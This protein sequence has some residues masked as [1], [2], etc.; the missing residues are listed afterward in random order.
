MHAYLISQ[1]GGSGSSSK[2]DTEVAAVA[3]FAPA[4]A[5]DPATGADV[6][7]D[8]PILGGNIGLGGAG[9]RDLDES[10]TV[11]DVAEAEEAVEVTTEACACDEGERGEGDAVVEAGAMTAPFETVTVPAAAEKVAD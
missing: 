5:A 11:V 3:P 2:A 7:P 1:P 8:A 10:V 4:A 9:P 6:V